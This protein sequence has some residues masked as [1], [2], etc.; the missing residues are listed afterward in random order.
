LA[1]VATVT[2]SG[3]EWGA[4]EEVIGVTQ[5]GHLRLFRS[6]LGLAIAG[7]LLS[8]TLKKGPILDAASV[9]AFLARLLLTIY[10]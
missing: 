7:G 1:V 9:F 2:N 5:F 6:F 10:Y 4:A 8:D 3:I